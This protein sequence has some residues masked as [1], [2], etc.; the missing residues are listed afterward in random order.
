MSKHKPLDFVASLSAKLATRS[1][2]VCAFLG[3]GIARACGL[4]DMATLLDQVVAALDADSR[5][6]FERQRKGRNLEEALTR[7]RRIAA[8]VTGEETFDG[9][10][11]SQA[12]A[13]DAKVCKAIV[14]ALD[15]GK[16]D[17]APVRRFAA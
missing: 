5:E 1:R 8:L 17:L 13:L 6:A 3:A 4:P 16:A 11:E 2:H 9:L 10:T 7:I 14:K 15:I 12:K